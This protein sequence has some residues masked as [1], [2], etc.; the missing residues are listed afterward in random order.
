VYTY[1]I[2]NICLPLISNAQDINPTSIQTK[3]EKLEAT[4][5]GRLGVFAINT[6]A[7]NI[8]I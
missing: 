6:A 3:L 4:S 2:S 5:G 8:R 7:N 1:V